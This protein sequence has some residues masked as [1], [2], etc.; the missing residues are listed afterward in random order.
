MRWNSYIKGTLLGVSLLT[1]SVTSIPTLAVAERFAMSYLYFGNPSGYVQAVDHTKGSLDMVSPSYFDLRDDGSLLLTEALDPAFIKEMHSK[2][3][4]V[5]PFLSNHWD[6]NKG[7]AA[8]NNRNALVKQIAAAIEKYNLDGVN[9]DIEN[10]TDKQRD[11]QTQL[12]KML[13]EAIPAHK[14]VSVAVAANPQGWTTGW[15]GSYDYAALS[16]VSDYLMIMTY[17]ESY[18]GSEPGPVAGLPFVEQ[19]IQYALKH[20]PSNK[21]VLGIPFYGR[22]WKSDGTMKGNAAQNHRISK[23]LQAYNGKTYYDAAKQSPKGV[24][25]IKTGDA[26]P[27]VHGNT[28]KPG[29]YT[30]WYE[31]E[32]SIQAKLN[33]VNKYDLKG[34]G[35]WSLT[36]EADG[37]W[38]YYS[39][40]LNG[41]AFVDT[42]GHW[43]SAYIHS[44]NERGWMT[45]T[46]KRTFAPEQR[47]T[48]AQ[49]AAIV[50]RLLQLQ[51]QSAVRPFWDVPSRHWAANDILMA[52]Q[53]GIMKGRADGS[54]GPEESIT[55]EELTVLL[56]RVLQASPSKPVISSFEDVSSDRWSA[57]SIAVLVENGI[58]DGYRDGTFRPLQAVTRAEMA[59]MLDLAAPILNEQ[60]K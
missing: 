58:V 25:T 26:L 60:F 41:S 47:L 51:P 50:A 43:A 16:K 2:G 38:D 11:D 13:R 20:V 55:R 6:R 53:A 7:I 29:T 8:L 23:L 33:L 36:E 35:N 32:Q 24:F 15:H 4:K 37:T 14:E 19:S 21:I 5:V 28:L 44:V 10:V 45:G 18:Q 17:D 31:N 30:V 54:F 9:V 49:S 40:W 57:A 42:T 48:R 22:Y 3:M 52:Q 39:A 46:A 34:A 12:V 56:A 27:N 59:K 1:L